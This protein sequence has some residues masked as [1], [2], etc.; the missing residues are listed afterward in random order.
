MLALRV[1][2]ARVLIILSGS[3]TSKLRQDRHWHS[4]L[5]HEGYTVPNVESQVLTSNMTCLLY[6]GIEPGPPSCQADVLT[7]ALPVPLMFYIYF[8][9]FE[10]QS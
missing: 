9:H 3:F 1:V 4:S 5:I 7:T 2:T 6:L 10:I 8:I